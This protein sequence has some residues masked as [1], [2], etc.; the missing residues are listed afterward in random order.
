MLRD[1]PRLDETA[2][3]KVDLESWKDLQLRI[4]RPFNYC[5]VIRH[6]GRRVGGQKIR[7]SD[8]SANA[9]GVR[10]PIPISRLAFKH[11][12]LRE[13]RWALRVGKTS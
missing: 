5:H 13:R 4:G 2:C 6:G 9:G 3:E 1:E 10:S 7:S 8:V 12:V 11:R